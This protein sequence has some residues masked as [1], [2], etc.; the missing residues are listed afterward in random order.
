MTK[1]LLKKLLH[2]DL[3]GILFCFQKIT[4]NV[5][6]FQEQLL[7]SV[8]L[9]FLGYNSP[10]CKTQKS[11]I[12]DKLHETFFIDCNKRFKIYEEFTGCS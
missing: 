7:S 3:S 12:F 8:I 4:Y 9:V 2:S 6:E 11:Q 5:L 10:S 1:D